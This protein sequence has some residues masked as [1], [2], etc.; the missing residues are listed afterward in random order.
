MHRIAR[1]TFNLSRLVLCLT[2]VNLVWF[3]WI[4]YI[5]Y[6]IPN[7]RLNH[8]EY[9]IQVAPDQN[10]IYTSGCVFGQRPDSR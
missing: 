2:Q 5:L 10:W 1:Y 8:A 3:L 4:F 7:P 9:D 6:T